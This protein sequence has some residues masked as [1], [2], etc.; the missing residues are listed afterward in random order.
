MRILQTFKHPGHS[1][2]WAQS[3]CFAKTTYFV[4]LVYERLYTEDLTN[5]LEWV[6]YYDVLSRVALTRYDKTAR[7]QIISAKR[8]NQMMLQSSD[9]N[10]SLVRNASSGPLCWIPRL[11]ESF[12]SFRCSDVQ[13]KS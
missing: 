4:T 5:I 2:L 11:T 3:I 1:Y 13:W 8:V 7:L 10:N 12:R 6:F 9:N